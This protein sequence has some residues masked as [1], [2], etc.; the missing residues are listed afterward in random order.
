MKSLKYVVMIY[1]S[2]LRKLTY[3]ISELEELIYFS[4]K[5]KKKT[6]IYNIKF[7]DTVHGLKIFFH[8][9]TI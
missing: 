4:T 8:S 1:Y 3:V 6:V 7:L 2:L 9:T 5:K